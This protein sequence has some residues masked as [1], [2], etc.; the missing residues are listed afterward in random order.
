M[1]VCMFLVCIL[2]SVVMYCLT[3]IFRYG[4]IL[5]DESDHTL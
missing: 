5:Q 2:I 4:S 1:A 3:I